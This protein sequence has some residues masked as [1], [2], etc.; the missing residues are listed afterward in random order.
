MAP[1][2]WGAQ[3]WLRRGVVGLILWMMAG[4]AQGQTMPFVVANDRGGLIGARVIEVAQLN[5]QH[6]RVELRGRFC[7]SSCTL[8]LGVE[9]LCISP[10][11]IFGFHGPSRHGAALDRAQFEHW[12]QTMA[13]HYAAPLRDWFL[14]DA[15]YQIKGI[16]RISGA[17]LIALGYPA[18]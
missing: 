3:P 11:T 17:K 6:R 2:C 13:Q 5:A 9:N 18:C 10:D 4:L 16:H 1:L 15:R 7:Y 14:R 12:S 8:Y